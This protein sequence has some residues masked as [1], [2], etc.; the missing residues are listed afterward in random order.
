MAETDTSHVEKLREERWRQFATILAITSESWHTCL[1]ADQATALL[2]FQN[3][4]DVFGCRFDLNHL[5]DVVSEVV[6]F[7]DLQFRY[8]P[9]E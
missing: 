8:L 1:S 2:F 3:E 7:R 4:D 9:H 5:I 6:D